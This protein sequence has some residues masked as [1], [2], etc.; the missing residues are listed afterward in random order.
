MTTVS[1][2]AN[3]VLAAVNGGSRNQSVGK[4]EQDKF[5]TLL[6]TQMKNQDPLNPL[7]NAQMT[8]QLAQLST[9]TGI[10]KL[11]ATMESF[12]SG[13]HSSQSLQAASLIG[14]A[15]L[16]PG[17]ETS[18]VKGQAVFGVELDE[19]ADKVTVNIK[20]ATGKLVHTMDLGAQDAGVIPLAWDGKTA[21]D[22]TLEDGR[23]KIEV[24]ATRGSD[25]KEGTALTFGEV[26]SVSL[27]PQ[28]VKLNLLGAG[29]ASMADV[30]QIL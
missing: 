28:G 18:L 26:L 21:D 11:N 20:D 25:I 19:A 3:D 1:N 6:V 30:R 7:D 13:F 17:A 4:S 27:G 16:V 14:R 8:S 5:M 24:V 15:V 29:E 9:L 22:V 12:V 10:E 23:Y 2:V